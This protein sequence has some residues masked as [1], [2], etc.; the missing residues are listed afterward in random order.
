MACGLFFP[1][2]NPTH[3]AAYN[4]AN[5]VGYANTRRSVTY[6]CMFL[7]DA[8]ISWKSKKQDRVALIFRKSKKQDKDSKSSME[9]EYWAMSLALSE[10]IWL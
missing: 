9:F 4:D 10:I 5:W 7:I 3:L 8:L 6:W 1:A 2:N